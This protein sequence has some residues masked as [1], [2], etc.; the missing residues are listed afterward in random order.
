M[1]IFI[2]E[3][4]NFTTP[5]APQRNLSCAGALVIPEAT[6]NDLVRSFV[7]LRDIWDGS[8]EEIKGSA[9]QEEQTDQTIALLAEQ[10]CIFF[11]CATEMSLNS[12]SV[13]ADFQHKQAEF[14][15]GD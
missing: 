2:D 5:Q 8:Q 13:I 14:I 1:L 10:G 9:L 15:A 3:S 11:V 12:G 7:R 4:G 6:H